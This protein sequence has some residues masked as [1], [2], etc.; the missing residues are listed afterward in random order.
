MWDRFRTACDRFFT[1]RHADLATR[2]AG[3]AE[4]LA[5]K[6][7]LCAQAEAIGRFDGLGPRGGGVQ[8]PAG[9]VEDDRA[10][11][12]EPVR[13][14][15]AALPRRLRSV[16]HPLRQPP[17]CRTGGAGRG[18]RG[19]LRRGRSVG[20]AGR[21][22]PPADGETPERSVDAEPAASPDGAG[23]AR[24]GSRHWQ[25]L[26]AGTGCAGRGSRHGA[27]AR[28]QVRGRRMA[29]LIARWPSA[30]AGTDLDPD[31][32]RKRM[33]AIVI[34][35][36]GARRVARGPGRCVGRSGT[37]ADQ[38]PRR[39][40]EGSAR[41][42]HDRRQGRG[43]HAAARGHR[44]VRQ[45][46]SAWSRIGHVPDAERRPL[47]SA[48]NAPARRITGACRHTHWVR[49]VWKVGQDQ[50]GRAGPVGPDRSGA[51]GR[52]G[53]VGAE[54]RAGVSPLPVSAIPVPRSLFPFPDLC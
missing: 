17:R 37:V 14:D 29:A 34:R 30:F 2:K 39:H 41:R 48:S 6:E 27:C 47:S 16:L 54:D 10:G 1:R 11:Q 22:R 52:S 18:T 24:K 31:A 3:W 33:E 4:N 44:D 13:S 12:E 25:P 51:S 28:Q 38:P 20:A 46:Q 9:R 45:A 5:K 43:R 7:A 8:A 26:A 49:C 42:Q 35:S 23:T 32:N 21:I 50:V 53:R 19:D 36:R 40:A 15:L